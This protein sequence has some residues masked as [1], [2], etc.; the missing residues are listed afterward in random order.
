MLLTEYSLQVME[1][2][3]VEGKEGVVHS[4]EVW[5]EWNAPPFARACCKAATAVARESVHR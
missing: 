5:L 1:P 2:E 3:R 4:E